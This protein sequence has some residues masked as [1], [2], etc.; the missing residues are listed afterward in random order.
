MGCPG[1]TTQ[2]RS[3]SSASRHFRSHAGAHQPLEDL[4]EVAGVQHDQPHA[5]QH[6]LLHAVHDLVLHLAVRHMAPPGQHVGVEQHFLGQPMLG[7]VQR[8][9]LDV[10]ALL[11]Q[12]IGD[13]NMHA[14]GIDGLHLR[15]VL[16]VA[17]LAP[18]G[19]TQWIC[20]CFCL[21]K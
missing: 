12:R 15:V 16:F 3:L 6:A 11:A 18:H 10:E 21:Q 1:L 7:L 20:H 19:Y 4:G 9:S 2:M 8:S 5:L 13:H 17:K 14:V